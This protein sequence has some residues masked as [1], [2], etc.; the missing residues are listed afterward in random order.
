MIAC[1]KDHADQISDGNQVNRIATRLADKFVKPLFDFCNEKNYSVYLKSLDEILNWAYE[2]YAEYYPKLND[3]EAFEGTK[4]NIFN[5]INRD[6]FLMAWG[7]KR[8]KQFIAENSNEKEYSPMY[9]INGNTEQN[10]FDDGIDEGTDLGK[11]LSDR[12]RTSMWAAVAST[13]FSLN[14]FRK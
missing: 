4:D 10:I 13:L 5:S 8:M 6:D 2:F 9:A 7:D 3:W 11:K 1:L 12:K 14:P